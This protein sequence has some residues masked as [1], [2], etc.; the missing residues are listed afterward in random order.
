ML[1]TWVFVCLLLGEMALYF[2]L[3]TSKKV[4]PYEVTSPFRT[5]I[6]FY[7]LCLALLVMGGISFFSYRGTQQGLRE[8]DLLYNRFTAIGDLETTVL[9]MESTQRGF[10][11]TGQK[12]YLDP[13]YKNKEKIHDQCESIK[14][15]YLGTLDQR[16]VEELCTLINNRIIT[17]ERNIELKS[18][19]K[20]ED[21]DKALAI[22]EG[23]NT[24]EMIVLTGRDLENRGM[25]EYRKI[26]D[27]FWALG[28]VRVYM[29]FTLMIAALVQM[30]LAA[31]LG[32]SRTPI[33]SSEPIS[34]ETF[35]P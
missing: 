3:S 12:L 17:L 11:I 2:I 30:I 19:G 8:L 16:R 22:N 31:I 20:K 14:K 10:L 29:S 34:G 21:L 26:M 6:F 7:V 33:Q 24:T 25:D 9:R 15:F 32:R 23:M 27:G 28:S 5:K 13:Y 35:S 1:W 18:T 4:F